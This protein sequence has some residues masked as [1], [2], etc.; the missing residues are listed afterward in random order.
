MNKQSNLMIPAA[1]VL[2]GVIIAGAFFFSGKGGN[3]GGNV[4]SKDSPAAGNE[5]DIILAPVTEKDHI[6]GNPEADIIIVEYSDLECPFCKNFHVTMNRIIDEYGKDGRVAWVYRHFP[7][8]ELHP[9]APQESEATECAAE[10]G[11]NETF[12][13]YTNRI[14]EITPSNNGLDLKQLPIIAEEV[15]LNRAEFEECLESGRHSG[16]VQAQYNDAISAGGRGTPH[17]V[18]LV[19][20]QDPAPL[21]GAAAFEQ[22]KGIIDQ[23]LLSIPN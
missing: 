1:I 21:S 22:V 10:L 15:G 19:K 3:S 20:G 23:A 6:L 13:A 17:S 9:K 11:G 8:V 4:A 18:F 2:A 16:T 14:F 7:L 5:T 12:W